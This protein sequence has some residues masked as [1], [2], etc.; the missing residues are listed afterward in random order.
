MGLQNTDDWFT[1]FTRC[2]V[3]ST[4]QESREQ[5][6]PALNLAQ[7]QEEEKENP[8]EFLERLPTLC[9]QVHEGRP[10]PD[11]PRGQ[12]GKEARKLQLQPS[13]TCFKK[14]RAQ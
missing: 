8:W 13:G 3:L 6:K 14:E 5:K 9:R 10:Y 2:Q 12:E 11:S 4:K 7:K 1:R